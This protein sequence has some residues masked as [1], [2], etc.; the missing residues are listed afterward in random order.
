MQVS[1]N[2][3]SNGNKR[4]SE[5]LNESSSSKIQ[6]LN[7]T[8]S[9]TSSNG[10]SNRLTI[11]GILEEMNP[12]IV[13]FN[14]IPS[15]TIRESSSSC[16]TSNAQ[17]LSSTPQLSQALLDLTDKDLEMD[18]EDSYSTDSD[19]DRSIQEFEN[20][21]DNEKD[22]TIDEP[23]DQEYASHLI[24]LEHLLNEAKPMDHD[25]IGGE[26]SELPTLPGLF[27]R[28]FGYV[29]LPLHELNGEALIRQSKLIQD[30]TS[31]WLYFIDPSKIELRNP[32]WEPSL[33]RLVAKVA[34]TLGFQG[35]IGYTLEKLLIFKE[36]S[37]ERHS[38]SNIEQVNY[39]DELKQLNDIKVNKKTLANIV[40]QLPSIH[41]GFKNF[42]A[43]FKPNFCLKKFEFEFI[44]NYKP[45]IVQY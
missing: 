30:E 1:Q 24:Q 13:N 10:R 9:S 17:V 32:D 11:A 16:L 27:I 31:S 2:P 43:Y 41:E 3:N 7:S 14:M 23:E 40:L 39:V 28:E 42:L 44:N 21:E 20:V 35:N 5:N 19:T 36:G 29:S 8:H 34:L 26:A 33:K 18:E 6:R 45:H 12:N 15:T 22:L 38:F 25:S 37:R 4:K